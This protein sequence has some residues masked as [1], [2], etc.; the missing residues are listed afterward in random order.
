MDLGRRQNLP[1]NMMN[2]YLIE[3]KVVK[4]KEIVAKVE[5]KEGNKDKLEYFGI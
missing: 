5:G 4:M 3:G 2:R 1:H